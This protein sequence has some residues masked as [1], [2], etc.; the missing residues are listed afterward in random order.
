MEETALAVPAL[1]LITLAL[2]A[3]LDRYRRYSDQDRVK[4]LT[5]QRV[6]PAL[7]WLATFVFGLIHI[8]NYAGDLAPWLWVVLVLPQIYAGAALGFV[9]MRF[10]LGAAIGFHGAY[11]LVLIGLSTLAMIGETAGGSAIWLAL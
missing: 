9:R 7:F 11:N 4:D 1:F 5:A 8:A 2:F 3:W 6:F 10:G